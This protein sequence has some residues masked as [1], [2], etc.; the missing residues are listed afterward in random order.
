[1]HLSYLGPVSCI[2]T[3]WVSSGLSLG[4]GFSGGSDIKNLHAVWE[5][6]FNPW[7]GKI[8]GEGKDFHTPVF[9]PGESMDRAFI[10]A[11]LDCHKVPQ[12]RW[13]KATGIY[14]LT[15]LEAEVWN[16]GAG[17]AAFPLKSLEKDPSLPRPNIT[18]NT[19]C[20]CWFTPLLTSIIMKSS[21]L[22]F[23]CVCPNVLFLTRTPAIVLSPP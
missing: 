14:S 16:Q 6:P 5:T 9:L 10:L 2:L 11:P 12:T 3:R 18:I 22:S 19:W 17:R 8:P 1:M 21:S 23:L 15:A 7:I 4:R 13:L 20:P